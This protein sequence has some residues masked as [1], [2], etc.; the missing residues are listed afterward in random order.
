MDINKKFNDSLEM[1]ES[2]NLYIDAKLKDLGKEVDSFGLYNKDILSFIEGLNQQNQL[3]IEAMELLRGDYA[4][5]IEDIL[6]RN[7]ELY[8]LYKK[9]IHSLNTSERQKFLRGL[10]SYLD[11]SYSSY[12]DNLKRENK[13]MI[14]NM[15]SS[16]FKKDMEDSSNSSKES[17][18][19]LKSFEIS[20]F[21]RLLRMEESIN[22]KTM[23][24]AKGLA[25]P[26]VN[27]TEDISKLREDMKLIDKKL[28]IVM[29]LLV[30]RLLIMIVF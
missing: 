25:R 4:L 23:A 16:K 1:T 15:N 19:R 20:T 12:I 5:V 29:V 3:T 30:F 17:L 6:A 13:L 24:Y 11:N 10:S 27:N 18:S 21:D 14:E 8:R 2:Y 7:E 22:K 26:I 9:D 28:N